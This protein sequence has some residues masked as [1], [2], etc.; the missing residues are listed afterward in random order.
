MVHIVSTSFGSA[1]VISLVMPCRVRTNPTFRV[2]II[3]LGPESL[4]LPK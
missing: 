1:D 2:W 4:N 3:P